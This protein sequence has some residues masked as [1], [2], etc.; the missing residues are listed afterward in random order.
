VRV[1]LVVPEMPPET[2]GGG[3]LVFDQLA[4][5][6]AASH[7]V[8]IATGYGFSS[9]RTLRAER[10][11]TLDDAPRTV[12]VHYGELVRNRRNL[13]FFRSTLPLTRG[14][15]RSR[16]D[17][18]SHWKPDVAHVHGCGYLSVDETALFLRRGGIPYVLTG[19]GMPASQV[20]HGLTGRAAYASYERLVLRRTVKGAAAVTA[21]SSA[22]STIPGAS[23]VSV[24][25]NGFSPLPTPSAADRRWAGGLVE[26]LPPGPIVLAAG[27]L[28]TDKGFDA[29]V[30]ALALD[31]VTA[32]L[33]IVGED[34]GARSSLL[35]SALGGRLLLPG[36]VARSQLAALCEHADV[37][38][39]PSRN[40]PFGL[41]ALEFLGAGLPTLVSDAGG[42]RDIFEL[43]PQC[44]INITDVGAMRAS[45]DR[46]L[47]DP[48]RL[49]SQDDRAQILDRHSWTS[50]TNS[51]LALLDMARTPGFPLTA[52]SPE[53]V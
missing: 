23:E 51:Y 31:P 15:S 26:E 22:C 3:G 25:P 44:R 10:I 37:A 46:V 28:A 6:Y 18:I 43:A 39:V 41:V 11:G 19:H 50:V 17:F 12:A 1:L 36:K 34:A 52:A 9:G 42:L 8:A 33:V 4:R 7:D 40:E 13:P 53:V 27:R 49:M 29:L 45:I 2:V 14:A 47:A 32:S 30:A 38:V 5:S 48:K 24:V 16:R 20:Q 21:L 35:G